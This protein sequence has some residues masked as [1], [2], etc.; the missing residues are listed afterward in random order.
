MTSVLLGRI[1]NVLMRAGP[2]LR[3]FRPRAL[4]GALGWTVGLLAGVAVAQMALFLSLQNRPAGPTGAEKPSLP[5][6]E[7]TPVPPPP[8]PSPAPVS[9]NPIIP[10]NPAPE[11]APAKPSRA[12][13]PVVVQPSPAPP[14][15]PKAV[16]PA[17]DPAAMPRDDV[18]ALVGDAIQKRRSGDM[19]GALAK[20]STA[21]DLQPGHPRILFEQA[22]TYEAMNLTEKAAATFAQIARLGPEKAG[23]LYA[24]AQR[25]L[26][27][28]LHTTES[29]APSD[30][31][32]FIGDIQEIRHPETPGWEKV[33]LHIDLHAR[34]GKKINASDVFLS[35]QF[36]DLVAGKRVEPTQADPPQA[37]WTTLP[38]DWRDPGIETVEVTYSLPPPAPGQQAVES[39]Q[40]LGYLVELYYQDALL[41]VIAQP[42]RLARFQVQPASPETPPR[43]KVPASRDPL[44]GGLLEDAPPAPTPN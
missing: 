14:G 4:G 39:R 3:I 35:V 16:I 36:F 15:P 38:A 44:G 28:G 30:A 20:L 24:I 7:V 22:A 8:A 6:P 13:E 21:A 19:G 32:L 18:R 27:D 37:H 31:D 23:A 25:R 43:A 5:P 29:T 26:S 33:D 10:P 34:P 2:T 17:T 40:Y 11:V 41:D 12:N 42:R 9:A 1:V